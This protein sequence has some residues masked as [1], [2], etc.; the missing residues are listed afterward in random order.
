V[1][2]FVLLL[3][4]PD[5]E[6][7]FAGGTIAKCVA[8]GARV[9]LLCAT[10]GERGA[11][12]G[13]CSIEELPRVREAELRAAAGI[14]GIHDVEFLPYE[15]QQL[16]RAPMDAMRRS[17][18]RI[19]R[20]L[21]PDVVLTFD[22]DGSNQHTDHVAMSRFAMD[23]IAAAADPRWYPE[24]GAPHAVARV[25]W[26]C[27]VRVWEL[28]EI[29]QPPNEPGIDYRIDIR[30]YRNVKEAAL[31]AHRT[32]WAGLSRLFLGNRTALDWECFRCS[33]GARPESVPAESVFAS[34][35]TARAGGG[36]G[37]DML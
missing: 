23:G 33:S 20:R 8:E 29:A 28:G 6:T 12:G 13:I 34:S 26:P 11:T 9:G 17:V 25:L 4:H 14:L 1:S 30:G 37:R 21:R 19:L 36:R 2:A 10:R 27:P 22:P 15:D 3:A 5:D 7:F 31:R 24:E 16:A 35:D 32:Q 18:V